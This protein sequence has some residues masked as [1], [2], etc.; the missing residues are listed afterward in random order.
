MRDWYSDLT[1]E[2][3]TGKGGWMVGSPAY[4]VG[5]AMVSCALRRKKDGSKE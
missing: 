2:E 1:P 5:P 3:L 4:F